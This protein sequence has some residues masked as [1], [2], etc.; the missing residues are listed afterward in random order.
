[1]KM[2]DENS[3]SDV[4]SHQLPTFQIVPLIHLKQV[5]A[6]FIRSFN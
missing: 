5:D 6:S 4:P 1:M 3:T 2:E